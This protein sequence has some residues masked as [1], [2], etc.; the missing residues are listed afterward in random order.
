MY[1]YRTRDRATFMA[2]RP[3]GTPVRVVRMPSAESVR[4]DDRIVSVPAIVLTYSFVREDRDWVFE[5]VLIGQ[6]NGALIDLSET[7]WAE[8]EKTGEYRLLRRSGSF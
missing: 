6:E 4:R 1:P 7:L 3:P 2:N 8:L 5:E